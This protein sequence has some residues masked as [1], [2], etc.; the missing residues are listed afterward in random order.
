MRR[1]PRL[2]FLCFLFS[3]ANAQ[4]KGDSMSVKPQVWS[5]HF[6]MTTIDQYHFAFKAPYSGTNSLADSVEK[7]ALS[8]T[9]TL[10]L[11][12]KLWKG[13]ALFFNPEISG[14]R[15]MSGTRGIAGFP[16]GETFRIGDP[17][18]ALYIARAYF[19]QVIAL[20][21]SGYEMNNDD[22][23]QFKERVPVSR[24]TLTAG[25]FAISDFFDDNKYSHD[26]RSQFF[27]WSL[28]S[29]GAWDYPANTRG[30]TIGFVAEL[31]KPG[32]ALRLSAVQVP[33]TANGPSMDA[34][35]FQ[36]NSKTI[37]LEKSYQI[38][39]RVG[40]ARLLIFHTSSQAPNYLSGLAAIQG[41][42]SSILPVFTGDIEWKKYHGIKYGI[43]LSMN[44]DINSN[45]GVFFRG[46]WNDGKTATW[47]FTEI[48]RSISAGIHIGGNYWKR[49]DDHIG[50]AFVVNGLSR[51]HRLFLQS[52][53]NGFI[54]GDGQLQYGSENIAE[55][56]YLTKLSSFLYVTADYQLVIHPAYN[57]SRGPVNVMGL[58]CH[59]EL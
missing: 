8:I 40:C 5:V 57:R 20:N 58:R 18:P 36:A 33:T 17:T 11:G 55:F 51:D 1:I 47:A 22:A 54:I 27:N 7:P 24:I 19:Q 25:K 10:F 46:S 2:L 48:D 32:W 13:A 59:I 41:G 49:K 50:C 53:Y 9:S 6:Q 26:P 31:V 29:N 30:Y 42:D 39:H 38:H 45:M 14:G 52:G 37:E 16:N 23:N 15:G 43:G 35:V 56:Y 44:Q 21:Q 4:F 28:M 34:K 12:R 3:T